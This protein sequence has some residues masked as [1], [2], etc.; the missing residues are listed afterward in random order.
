MTYGKWR[1]K[2]TI[3]DLGTRWSGQLHAPAILPPQNSPR[4]LLDR[5]LGGTPDRLD[6]AGKRKISCHCRELNPGRPARNSQLCR[7]SYL[8]FIN[9][10]SHD[11]NAV[12]VV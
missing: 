8:G 4:Y 6:V 5:T 2:S 12:F 10:N 9:Y 1:Y 7:L 3:P 11:L